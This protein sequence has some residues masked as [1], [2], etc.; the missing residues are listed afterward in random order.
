LLFIFTE[1]WVEKAGFAYVMAQLAMF[2]EDVHGFPERV[3]ENLDQ[4]LMNKGVVRRGI[5][6]I[7]AASSG[8]CK[9]HGVTLACRVQNGPDFGIALWRA[10]SHGDVV[11]LY[12]R[13][14]PRLE[15]KREIERRQR[16]FSNDD[17]M[18]EFDGDVLR[19]RG[20][21]A[22]AKS[23]EPAAAKKAFRHF[24][25]SFGQAEGFGGEEGFDELIARLQSLADLRR[26]VKV[27]RH[28]DT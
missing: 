3:V 14:Q 20:V 16:A 5:T 24:A 25:A 26:E 12:E 15:G 7:G 18:H 23:E 11:R 1:E 27:R 10:E 22:T 21:R 13:S 6:E 19:I 9:R 17:R 4:F 8:Q 28:L 2:E